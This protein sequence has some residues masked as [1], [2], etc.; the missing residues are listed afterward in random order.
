ME[1]CVIRHDKAEN[2]LL[3]SKADL[4]VSSPPYGIG[5]SYESLKTLDDYTKWAETLIPVLKKNLKPNGAICWQVGTHVGENGE[6]VPLD[7]VY[8]PIFMKNGFT[9]KNRIVWKFGSGLHS[10]SRFS[11]RYEVMLWFVLDPKQYTFNL[12][13]VRIDSKEPGKRAY[14]GPNKGS[15]SGNPL[16]K[17]PA[18]VWL[19]VADEWERE[20]WTF[21]NVKSNHP[22]KRNE[23]PCQFPIELAERCILACSNVGDLIYDPFAGTGSTGCAAMF[24]ERKFV[25]VDMNTDYIAIA[26]ERIAAA[27]AGT[28]KTRKI[29]TPI[30]SASTS[31]KTRQIPEEWREIREEQ[32]KKRRLYPQWKKEDK[33]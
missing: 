11:G 22:E 29:G 10:D 23:H 13:P 16:G 17:N 27:V 6:Y 14:K 25:G 2:V 28:L 5:K 30:Q 1:N 9:L 26:H 4:I 32:S 8:A 24:H 12:D 19:I 31:A 7:I 20:E 15:L 3:E 21:P 18:D 33:E